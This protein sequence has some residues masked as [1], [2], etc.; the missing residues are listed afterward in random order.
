MKTN[1]QHKQI[2]D[3]KEQQ[4]QQTTTNDQ[5]K[6]IND[7]NQQSQQAT[8]NCIDEMAAYGSRI[9]GMHA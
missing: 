1:D 9:G 2:N 7:K 4:S 5:H 8:T 3:K 6:Q